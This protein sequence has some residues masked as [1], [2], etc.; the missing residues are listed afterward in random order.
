MEYVAFLEQLKVR[1]ELLVIEIGRGNVNTFQ[2]TVSELTIYGDIT[3]NDNFSFEWSSNRDE[4][5]IVR[6][7]KAAP[8]SGKHRS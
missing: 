5:L 4:Q 6:L 3:L 1:D 8:Y 2:G 7:S